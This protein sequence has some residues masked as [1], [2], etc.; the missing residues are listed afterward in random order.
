MSETALVTAGG[1]PATVN[2]ALIPSTAVGIVLNGLAPAT[3]SNPAEISACAG[4]GSAPVPLL[5]VNFKENFSTA[6]KVQGGA[7]INAVAGGWT[8]PEANT[9]TGY[10]AAAGFPVANSGT[11]IK[12]T[13]ANIPAGMTVY[14]PLSVASSIAGV[15]TPGALQLVTSETGPYAPA[16]GAG[17]LTATGGTAAAIYEVT[18][19][20]AGAS[21]I[22]AYAIPFTYT[23]TPGAVTAATAAIAATVQFAT[24]AAGGVPQFVTGPS[25]VTLTG[26]GVTICGTAILFPYISSAGGF[27]TGL[28]I[29]NTSTDNLNAG[30]SSVTPQTGVCALNFYG[31]GAP[32]AAIITPAVIS[33]KVYLATVSS[34]APGFTGY[35]IAN[36]N[37]LFAQGFAY[38]SYDLSQGNGVSMGYLGIIL[39]GNTR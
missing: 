10:P 38:I 36:C 5:I 22:D 32:A 27:D 29:A 1:A 15:N 19:Q 11:R 2:P 24:G 4:T 14:A 34:M 23:L 35:L 26:P 18:A 33:G 31:P 6:F 9:E 12:I 20:A 17:A 37:F 30:K 28:A 21:Q 3:V 25:T 13:F 8:E 7:A 39:N 16:T